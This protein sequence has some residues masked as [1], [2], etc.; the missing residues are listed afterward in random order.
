MAV[1]SLVLGLISLV[2]SV[3]FGIFSLGW[4]GAI[5]GIIS[6]VLGAIAKK[7]CPEQ[8]GKATA[9]IILSI[10]GLAWGVIATISC[11]ACAGAVAGASAE[12]LD[13]L[14]SYGF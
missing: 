12:A 10:I 5:C 11:L 6:I 2:L 14:S 4:V 8:S 3:V 9:G 13:T 7:K 1:A